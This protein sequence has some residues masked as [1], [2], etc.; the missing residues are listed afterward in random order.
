MKQKPLTP[1]L[2]EHPVLTWKRLARM[3]E[4]AKQNGKAVPSVDELTAIIRDDCEICGVVFTATGGPRLSTP[5]LQHWP[6]GRYSLLCCTCNAAHGNLNEPDHLYRRAAGLW[7]CPACGAVDHAT[8]R[9]FKHSTYCRPC[10]QKHSEAWKAA[11]RTTYAAGR[12]EYHAAHYAANRERILERQRAAYHA[13]DKER[14][15]ERRKLDQRRH[16]ARVRMEAVIQRL[17]A[18]A[19]ELAAQECVS[20]PAA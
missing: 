6:D 3:R 4:N 12:R 14:T 10:Q 18:R 15:R 19:D 5:S 2:A 13:G 9:P 1:E 16:R 20:V 8:A 11:N 17:Q 7:T